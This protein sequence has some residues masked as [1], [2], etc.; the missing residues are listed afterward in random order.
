MFIQMVN[1]KEDS[2]WGD[3]FIQSRAHIS[4]AQMVYPLGAEV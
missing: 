3:Y 2:S 1:C 4:R